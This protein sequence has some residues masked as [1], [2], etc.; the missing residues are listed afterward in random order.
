M[1][2]ENNKGREKHVT[3]GGGSVSRREKAETGRPVGANSSYS[4]RPKTGSSQSGSSSS[5]SYSNSSSTGG[6]GGLGSLFGSSSN[7]G[8]SGGLSLRKIIVIGIVIV[9][10]FL[11]LRACMNS[12]AL[13]LGSSGDLLSGLTGTDYT[14]STT[15]T[16]STGVSN[17]NSAALNTTVS[18]LAR[19]KRTQILGNGQ[20]TVTVMI[21]MLGSDLE[22]SGGMATSDLNEILSADIADNVNIILETGGAS[23]WQNSVISAK[24][25]QRYQCVSGGLKLLQD[26]LG[27]LNMTDPNTLSDF[28]T[29]CKTNF[30]ANRY[31]L[32]MWDHGGGSAAGYGHDEYFS[33]DTMTL[34]EIHS[35][36]TQAD[37][38]FDFI[39]FDACLMATY[40]T[41][42]MLEQHAD[43]MIASEETEPGIGWFYTNWVSALSDNTS[44]STPELGKI[45]IDDFNVKCA[46]NS[47]GEQ[48][49]L[50]I[51][52]LAEFSGTV[53]EAFNAFAASTGDMIDA[54]QYETVANARSSS[55]EFGSPSKLNQIDLIHLAQNLNTSEANALIDAL[56]GA[57]KYNRTSSTISNANGISIYFP[58]E[59]LSS[60]SGMLDTYDEIGMDSEY[61]ST[62]KRFANMEAGGQAIT[63]GTSN[64]LSSILSGVT[65][66]T[67]SVGSSLVGSLIGSLISNADFSSILGSSDST[68]GSNWLN[69]DTMTQD[70]TYYET[71]HLDS[72]NLVLTEKN[73]GYV[74]SLTDAEWDM[75]QEIQLNVFL[76]DGEGYIDLGLDNT[77]NFDDDGD[78]IIDYDGTW[79]ALNEQ[80]VAYY[81]ISNEWNGDNY[82]ITGY[83]PAELNG[84]E[85]QIILSFTND[86]PNGQVLGART[87]YDDGSVAK[88]LTPLADGDV[89]DFLCDFYNYDET[90]DD[91]YYLG[92]PMTV[93]GD[94]E[95]SN[96]S[97]GDDPVL[98][99]YMLTDI[100]NNTYWLPAMKYE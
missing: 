1:D 56:Q 94:I 78:L 55:R 60:L 98:F 50:S 61:S 10:G 18:N 88:G 49:T 54:D 19:D 91:S 85:V 68:T 72:A 46:Q 64:P 27:R 45:I 69:T 51:I 40:E 24:T 31:M 32:V 77:F 39:G 75:V 8:T 28:V 7:K 76:D 82:A 93:S 52:D 20:D 6:F 80:V 25:N 29:Y 15:E 62:I 99:T 37:V 70:T 58:F 17:T 53:P 3:S 16:T 63:T 9:V 38:D 57:I 14:S 97:V 30:P 81:M 92:D 71:N 41:A 59:S 74:L 65:G 34:D 83:V 36:L 96:V 5:D 87:V 4:S 86:V 23:K 47:S 26:N 67:S 90:Y 79:L 89:L 95:I 48:T 11:I 100:Y 33:G 22:S 21:Y 44:I 12:G 66:N 84:E 43:Y 13:D 73:D 42:V 2:R 35:A